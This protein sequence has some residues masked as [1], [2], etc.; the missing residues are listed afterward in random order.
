MRA[1]KPC[2]SGSGWP[3]MPI[4]TMAP[5]GSSMSDLTAASRR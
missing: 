5:R 4:A 2:S 3:F 1:G